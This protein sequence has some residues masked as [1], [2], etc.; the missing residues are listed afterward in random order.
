MYYYLTKSQY[1]AISGS[2]SHGPAWTL[3][4]SHCIVHNDNNITIS[5]YTTHYS[6]STDVNDWRFAPGSTEWQNWMTQEEFDGNL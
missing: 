5:N 1:D 3:N 2:V 4:K 6:S